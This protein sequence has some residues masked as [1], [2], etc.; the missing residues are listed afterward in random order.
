MTDDLDP[1]D[2]ASAAPIHYRGP[3]SC[4][5]CRTCLDSARRIL[6]H[7][8]DEHPEVIAEKLADRRAN[9]AGE[10]A[11]RRGVEAR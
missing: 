8:A 10:D 7:L 11:T 9:P 5:A 2:A 4:I 6:V 3:V 1:E